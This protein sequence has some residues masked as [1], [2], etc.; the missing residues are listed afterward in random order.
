M[1]THWN[2]QGCSLCRWSISSCKCT[3]SSW[4]LFNMEQAAK[5]IGLYMNSDKTEFMYFKQEGAIFTLNGKLLKFV[6]QFI[7]LDSNISSTESDVNIC[8]GKAWTTINRLLNI[9]KSNLSDKYNIFQAVAVS[10]L[11]YGYNTWTLTK[12]LKKKLDENYTRILFREST[13]QH[14]GCGV[15]YLL[16]HKLSN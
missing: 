9:W 15:T 6:D 14:G 7:Y 16:S 4:M 13:L 12:H 10:M 1:V 8:I 11:L 3:S 5:G 2:Y